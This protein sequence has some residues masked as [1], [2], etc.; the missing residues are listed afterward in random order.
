MARFFLHIVFLFLG[1]V[2]FAQENIGQNSSSMKVASVNATG[3]NAASSSGSVAYSIGVIYYTNIESSA[4]I[5]SQGVQQ[6]VELEAKIDDQS[7]LAHIVAYPNP[8][9]DYVI[10]DIIDFKNEPTQYQI[11]SP[12]GS[13]LKTGPIIAGTTKLTL[14]YLSDAIYFIRVSV[15]NKF[16]ETF[17][18]IKL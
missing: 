15:L 1:L 12:S 16:E 14:E 4:N 6:S 11:F 5:L 9:T 18:I 2:T 8:A 17:K 7:T 13:I 3:G 10:V